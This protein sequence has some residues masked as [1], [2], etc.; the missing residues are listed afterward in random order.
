MV[1]D[2]QKI[3]VAFLAVLMLIVFIEPSNSVYCGPI[4]AAL[5]I[6][7][8]FS[9]YQELVA[10]III[11]ANDALGTI[12]AGELSF[13]Y[14]LFV[15]LVVKLL[16]SWRFSANRRGALFFVFMIF[17][18]H[19]FIIEFINFKTYILAMIFLLAIFVLKLDS[20]SKVLQRFFAGIAFVVVIIS[21]HAMLTG[22]VEFYEEDNTITRKGILGVGIGDANFSAFVLN[23]GI[24]CLLNFVSA[25]WY[26]K[27]ACM[28][29]ILYA[30]VLTRSVSGFLALFLA[31]CVMLLFNSKKSKGIVGVIVFFIIVICAYQLYGSLSKDLHIEI[32]DAFIERLEEKLTFVQA[33]DISNA[34]T[35]R[36]EHA[37]AY[38]NYIFN[39]QSAVKLL[40][41]G[42]PIIVNSVSGSASH[43]TYLDILL[44]FGIVG[45]VPFVAYLIHRLAKTLK[46]SDDQYRRAKIT[47][48]VLCM[49]FA[50]GLS[51]YAD[52]VWSLWVAILFLI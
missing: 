31:I 46:N 33:G 9:G 24:I 12:I 48:K 43:N 4:M 28:I 2:P 49:F 18:S 38:F 11:V 44:Q 15:L 22:G 10:A 51:I 42:N 41:G 32:V 3:V 39:E 29:P 36:S 26:Y 6:Y 14:L 50:L 7:L 34:T 1:I 23:L 35:N 37:T 40:F 21:I 45:L 27:V 8:F 5:F 17:P 20:D 13:Q 16:I 25:K 52:N 30:F 47:L 19:L